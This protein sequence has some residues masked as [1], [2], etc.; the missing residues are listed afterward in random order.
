MVEGVARAG[1][2]ASQWWPGVL[3]SR[4][5]PVECLEEDALDTADID[6]VV[7]ERALAGSIEP[8]TTIALAEGNEFLAGAQ[9]RPW[10]RSLEELP[11]EGL[12]VRADCGC[13]A[14]DTVGRTGGYSREIHIQARSLIVAPGKPRSL[15]RAL[16]LLHP[17]T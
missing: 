14:D 5:L 12:D 6:E 17:Q 3:D 13:P 15:S 2:A 9:L 11:G 4:R 8:F 10:E 7:G 1:E 16:R